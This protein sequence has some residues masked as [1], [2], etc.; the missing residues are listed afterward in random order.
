MKPFFPLC[1]GLALAVVVELPPAMAQENSEISASDAARKVNISGRQRMLSQRMA[2]AA[3]L[4]AKDISFASSF[5]QLTQAYSLYDRSNTG[6][7]TGDDGMGLLQE[8]SPKVLDALAAV[9]E[10][11]SVYQGIVETGIDNGAI[12][13]AQLE[14]LDEASLNV[15]KYMN[16]AVFKTARAYASISPDLPLGLTITVDVAGRQRMLTQKAVKEAC[17]M[18]IAGEPLVYAD[19]L[20]ETIELFDLSL[21]ALRDGHDEVGVIAAPTRAIDRK[22]NEVS[23]LWKPLKSLLDRAARGE[24][25]SDRDLSRAARLSEPLLSTMN[26]AVGMYE[27]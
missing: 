7:R 22:L 4:M 20:A 24:V 5:D 8:Q 19:Q 13:S 2:K 10:P 12:E 27:S 26:E 15:L 17:M 18:S 3:C 9:D 23:E 25:L 11:W 16:I 6:L 14:T 21:K 1:L